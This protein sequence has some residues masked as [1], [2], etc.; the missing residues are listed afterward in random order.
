MALDFMHANHI[1]G[2]G[3]GFEPQRVNNGKLIITG[4]DGINSSRDDVLT[5]SVASFPLP[6]VSSGIVEVGYLNEKRKFAGNP[7]YDDLSVSFHDYVD[8]EVATILYRWRSLVH[9]P[10][11]GKTGLASVYKKTAYM[12]IY[13]PE[14]SIERKFRLEGVWLQSLDPGEIDMLGEDTVKIQC[15]LAIDKFYPEFAGIKPS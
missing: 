9:D 7:I 3:G 8:K 5:L 11:T 12:M 14:G 15:T 2:A 6:K 10:V 4:L 1:G 13:S